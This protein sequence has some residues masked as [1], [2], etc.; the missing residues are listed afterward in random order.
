MKAVFKGYKAK[1]SYEFTVGKVCDLLKDE[2]ERVEHEC[3]RVKDDSGFAEVVVIPGNI[4]DF[5]E[6]IPDEISD[7]YKL[8]IDNIL[9]NAQ[10]NNKR[11]KYFINYSEVD[12]DD[13]HKATSYCADLES[14]GVDTSPVKFEVKFE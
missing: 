4:Y 10:V 8:M 9:K 11:L 5:E 1:G 2:C 7:V 3:F 14:M 13:F 6:L 12:K